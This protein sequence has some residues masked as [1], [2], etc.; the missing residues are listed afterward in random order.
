MKGLKQI[1]IIGA[2]GAVLILSGVA[3]AAQPAGSK[4]FVMEQKKGMGVLAEKD[5]NKIRL[6]YNYR[7]AY[8]NQQAVWKHVHDLNT[9]EEYVCST[10]K[11]CVNTKHAEL[12]LIL[13]QDGSSFRV[14]GPAELIDYRF[15]QFKGDVV[16]V[17][18][19]AQK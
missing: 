11:E 15:V 7:I 18:P 2:A 5:G 3:Q 17:R 10:S 14:V 6:T 12:K 13:S 16:Q 19:L 1:I 9:Q 8:E 4:L